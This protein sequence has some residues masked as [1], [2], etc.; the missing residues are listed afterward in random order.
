MFELSPPVLYDLGLEE[1][2][3]WLAEHFVK[4]YGLKI[5]VNRD[6]QLKP[7]KTEGNIILFQAVK[8]LLF[9]IVKHAQATT[10][11]I[12]IQRACND[13]R[14]IVED[15]GIGFEI[16]LI[17]HKQHKLKG[18]GLFSIYERLEY[19]GGSMIIDSNKTQ[20]TKITLLMPMITTT[21]AELPD[22]LTKWKT[23]SAAERLGM[24]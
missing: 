24:M 18:F 16:N 19:F 11:I 3:E 5:Q 7:L 2:I 6:E 22:I 21:N 13:L 17:D 10:A 23:S 14:I 15:D 12:Y 4:E 9:N 1:A 8:E 20:G